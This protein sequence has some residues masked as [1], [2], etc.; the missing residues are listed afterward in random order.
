METS[1]C[2]VKFPFW[3]DDVAVTRVVGQRHYIAVSG[4][5]KETGLSF[6]NECGCPLVLRTI[7]GK[8]VIDV[9]PECGTEMMQGVA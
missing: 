5:S 9:C 7:H 4:S 3:D 2:G 6:C 1:P 8:R